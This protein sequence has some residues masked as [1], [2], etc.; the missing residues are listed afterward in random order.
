MAFRRRTNLEKKW[1]SG[2]SPLIRLWRALSSRPMRMLAVCL[3]G[4]SLATLYGPEPLPYTLG[5]RIQA[6][7]VALVDFEVAD[8]ATTE[9]ERRKAREN[10]P[11]HYT[12]DESQGRELMR[13]LR[14]VLDAAYQDAPLPSLKARQGLKDILPE[15]LSALRGAIR[16]QEDST[17]PSLEGVEAAILSTYTVR[18]LDREPRSPGSSASWIIVHRGEGDGATVRSLPLDEVTS[19]ES[20]DRIAQAAGII[21][22]SLPA[23]L[24]EPVADLVETWL[25]QTA[26]LHYDADRTSQE[27]NARQETVVPA[28]FAFKRGEAFVVPA[29]GAAT[30]V[31]TVRDVELLLAHRAAFAG[32]LESDDPS[33]AALKLETRLQAAGR[34]ALVAIVAIGLVIYVSQHQARMLEHRSN[35]WTF[36]LLVI[37]TIAA[38]RFFAVQWPTYRELVLIPALCCAGAFA[39]FFPRR[40]AIGAMSIVCVLAALAARGSLPLMLTMSAGASVLAFQLDAVR[41]RTRIITAGLLTAVAAALAGLAGDLMVRESLAFAVHRAVWAAGCSMASAFF[42]S[43]ILPFVEGVFRL[44]TPLMLMQYR[45]SAQPLLQLLA[46]E[47]PGTYQ[48]SLTVSKL[49]DEACG[50]IGADA[51]LASVG[52]L[53]HD[54]GK[55]FKPG[56]FTENQSAPINRHENLAPRM[57]LLIILSHVKDG[58]ELAREYKLPGALLPFIREHHGTTL[59]RYFHHIA[60]EK[61]PAAAAGK[62]GRDVD[63]A[64]FRYPGPKPR[65]RET[66]VLMLCDGVEGAVR[67]LRDPS[68]GRIESVVHQIVTDRLGDG[69]FD[70]CEMTLAAIHKVEQALVKSLCSLYHGRVAYPRADAARAATEPA[71]RQ[72]APLAS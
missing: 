15:R 47:A 51:L 9:F 14:A 19:L 37:G 59:V 50:A 18:D 68:P 30:D 24:R 7:V 46:R 16:S 22:A 52:A 4:F 2:P 54:I 34:L 10:A 17:P 39:I 64:E 42:V 11:S 29:A 58:V 28:K 44:A 65:S 56:Y 1:K 48:H 36:A 38:S 21:V 60:S 45:D 27:M 72:T 62:H 63:E 67:S 71:P 3:A 53:Y 32:F 25:A 26:T 66:A 8:R 57:S 35:R 6:P 41:S 69:Q 13:R 20:P 23:P 33:A 31:L 49:A 40:F 70:E 61:Q 12:F 55:I 43:G 5:Q